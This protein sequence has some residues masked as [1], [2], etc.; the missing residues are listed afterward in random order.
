MLLLDVSVAKK[1]STVDRTAVQ[2][3]DIQTEDNK[4]KEYLQRSDTAV[5]FAEPVQTKPELSPKSQTARQTK[6]GQSISASKD[7]E[8]NSTTA[9]ES[10]IPDNGS[11][12]QSKSDFVL[13]AFTAMIE[14]M[15]AS[16]RSTAHNRFV[17]F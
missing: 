3:L 12:N 14:G 11:S 9:N 5:I 15:R 10:E 7:N 17:L 8:K 16:K 13:I 2:C 4:I 1:E 6:L